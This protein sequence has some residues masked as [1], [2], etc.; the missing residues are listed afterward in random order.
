MYIERSDSDEKY[1]TRE[2]REPQK[3]S[4]FQNQNRALSLSS[5]FR[6]K[7]SVSFIYT[8]VEK[9]GGKKTYASG[10]GSSG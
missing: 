8:R 3:Y 9:T 7:A 6:E 10:G 1:D 2:T 4:G 5:S